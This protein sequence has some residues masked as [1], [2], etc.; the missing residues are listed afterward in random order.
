MSVQD[1][2]GKSKVFLSST[3]SGL[4]SEMSLQG[5][6][7]QSKVS[8][9][10]PRAAQLERSAKTNKHIS[11]VCYL[12]FLLFTSAT[13]A[14]MSLTS[15][16]MW[17]IPPDLFFSR[18]PAMGDFSPSGCNSSNFVFDNSTKTVVT[19]CSGRSWRWK[20]KYLWDWGEEILSPGPGWLWPPAC[21][22]RELWPPPGLARR[23]Q[24]GSVCPDSTQL[25]AV[26][27]RL[28]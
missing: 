4:W 20:I 24:H 8:N 25:S 10:S 6:K 15:I 2:Q 5:Q 13:A 16:Q 22:C 28:T 18:Y 3:R 11:E 26:M 1:Q 14:W 27:P 12:I 17:C 21:L 19:P 23:W 7:G 9:V